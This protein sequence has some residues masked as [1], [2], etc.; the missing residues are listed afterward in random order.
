[1]EL[2]LGTP[3]VIGFEAFWW[4]I[5]FVIT[6]LAAAALFVICLLV[7]VFVAFKVSL[8]LMT[9]EQLQ[10]TLAWLEKHGPAHHWNA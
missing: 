7:V 6:F 5:W 1:L 3:E 2:S 9:T 10:A 8:R 4:T